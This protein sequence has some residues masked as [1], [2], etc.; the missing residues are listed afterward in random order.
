MQRALMAEVEKNKAPE[1]VKEGPIR[2]GGDVGP[3]GRGTQLCARTPHEFFPTST[4]AATRKEAQRKKLK[5]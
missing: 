1:R 2:A 4:A 3:A 5:L